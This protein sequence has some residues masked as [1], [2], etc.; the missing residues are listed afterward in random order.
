MDY[1]PLE[2]SRAL[3]AYVNAKKNG[4]EGPF[5]I[6]ILAFDINIRCSAV[7]SDWPLRHP[8]IADIG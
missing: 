7:N 6:G 5:L 8:Q 2:E 4:P 1:K 3:N